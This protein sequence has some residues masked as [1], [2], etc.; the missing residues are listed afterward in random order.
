MVL[1]AHPPSS[2]LGSPYS[3]HR[4]DSGLSAALFALNVR[5]RVCLNLGGVRVGAKSLSAH[6]RDD[7]YEASVVLHALLRPVKTQ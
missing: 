7:V 2:P 6:A 4:D 3:R 5:T 1:A